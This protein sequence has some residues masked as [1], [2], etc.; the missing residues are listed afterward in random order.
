MDQ[1]R[2]SLRARQRQQTRAEIVRAA[3]DL[4][5][6][7]GYESVTADAIAA[8]VGVSRATFFNYFPRKEMILLDVAQA[9]SERLRAILGE[10]RARRGAASFGRVLQVL[11]KLTAENARITVESK[12]LLIEVFFAQVARGGLMRARQHAVDALADVI[13]TIPGARNRGAQAIAETLFAVYLATMLEWLM[14]E[15]APQKW[16]VETMKD[17]LRM[18]WEGA[19]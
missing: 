16:L 3:F 5:A 8:A 14:R 12:K 11:L 13:G 18:V 6:K 17:R 19:V 2:P 1:R 15:R 4:F 10:L 7:H 9:R